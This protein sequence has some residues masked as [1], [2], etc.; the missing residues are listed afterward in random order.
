[1]PAYKLSIFLNLRKRFLKKRKNLGELPL[2]VWWRLAEDLMY[3]L[4][5]EQF[6]IIKSPPDDQVSLPRGK[7]TRLSFQHTTYRREGTYADNNS[8]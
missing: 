4:Y 7:N 3:P 8:I 6:P 5:R 2:P 1:M